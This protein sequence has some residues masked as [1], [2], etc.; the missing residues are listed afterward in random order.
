MHSI[1]ISRTTVQHMC[2]WKGIQILTICLISKGL[3]FF[4]H[5]VQFWRILIMLLLAWQNY[6]MLIGWEEYNYFINCTAVQLMIFPTQ[7][8]WR[9]GFLN[10][11]VKRNCPRELDENTNK[12]TKFCCNKRNKWKYEQ[13]H[14]IWLILAGLGFGERIW[15]WHWEVS[16]FVMLIIS[17]SNFGK[18]SKH[19]SYY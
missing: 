5:P 16:N 4:I 7:T 15:C 2:N 17:S 9:K 10:T 19:H 11:N 14:Q 1:N 12:S 8:E 3:L 18:T 6:W 13:K